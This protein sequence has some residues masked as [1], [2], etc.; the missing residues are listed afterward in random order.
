MGK[1]VDISIAARYTN[2][3]RRIYWSPKGRHVLVGTIASAQGSDLDFWDL[4]F[5]GEK[6]EDSKDLT[7]NLQLV[8]SSDHYGVTEVD[9]VRKVSIYPLLLD[10]LTPCRILLDVM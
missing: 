8:A 9:W 10:T 6:P 1:I 7:A 4:D 2:T 5:E 3:F